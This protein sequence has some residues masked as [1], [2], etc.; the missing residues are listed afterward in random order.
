MVNIAG[1]VIGNLQEVL[2][3]PYKPPPDYDATE[4]KAWRQNARQVTD[5]L[6]KQDIHILKRVE[7]YIDRFGYTLNEVS[8]KICADPMFASHF[9]KEPRRTGFHERVAAEW[10]NEI[11]C[12][13][14]F[15]T[16]P[17]AGVHAYYVTSDGEIR[18]GLKH[19]PSKSLDFKWGVGDTKCYAMHK[20]T[21]EGGGNQDS[22]FNEMI[23]ILKK[24]HSCPHQD[25]ILLVVVDGAY[26]TQERM[27]K[28]IT[29]T[30]THRPKSYATHIEGVPKILEEYIT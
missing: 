25:T 5:R 22:Q 8:E 20:Y 12:V 24:F 29:H 2:S 18:I 27:E 23:D 13:A 17:K 6:S 4:C 7:T 16:L 28:L 21:K 15:A 26:Y 30:R 1:A 14:N 11:E 9:A 3:I 10:I 19:R